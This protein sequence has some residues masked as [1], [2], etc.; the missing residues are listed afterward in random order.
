MST[1]K[2]LRF[3]VIVFIFPI[4]VYA[5]NF[6]GNPSGI[7]W[8]QINSAGARVIFPA[9]LD[10]Q[11][12]RIHGIIELLDTTT[13]HSIGGVRRKW[14]TVLLNQ[15]TFSN[16]Y[17]RLAPVLSEFYMT[18]NQN[19]FEEGGLRW[20][21]NLVIHENRHMQQLANF[22]KGITK[23]F[24]FFLGQEGQLLA[25]GITIPNYFFEGDAV[26]QETLVSNQG[27]GRMPYFYNGFKALW[28]ENKHYSWMKLRSGSY[29]DF[30]PDHYSLGYQL[31]AYGNATYGEDFWKKV[32]QDAVRF[33]GI[34]Y[35]FNRAIQRYSGKS[36]RQFRQAALYFFKAQSFSDSS[37]TVQYQYLT[38]TKRNN[39]VDY[40][41]PVYINDDS[42]LVTKQS[43]REASAFY[44]LVN[45]K[46]KKLRVKNTTL[47]AYYSYNHGKIVYAS[48]QSDP[49]RANRDYSVLQ[50]VDIKTGKQKQITRK[51]KYFSPDINKDATEIIAV[52]VNTDGTNYLHRISTNTGALLIQVPNPNNYFF[53]QTKYI[54]ANNAATIVR[55]AEGKIAMLKI[56]LTTGATDTIIDFSFTLL[57]YP[58]VKDDSIYFNAGSGYN[59]KIFAVSIISKKIISVSNNNN[60]I[61]NPV[62][63]GRGE[64]LASAFTA[65]GFR[66]V[67]IYRT[68]SS[69]RREETKHLADL[70]TPSALQGKG[71]G[72]LYKFKQNEATVTSYKK[73]FQLFN[74]H[75]RRAVISDPK[76]GYT[77]SS[78]NVLSSFSNN[79]TYTYNRNE[80]SHS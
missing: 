64:V 66:L 76:Y 18:P 19:N 38:H 61:Y 4:S 10:S 14:N 2:C 16:A 7:K 23:I 37:S 31:V 27:R 20:D 56:D 46:E 15:T 80:K 40:L 41:Y 55:N 29:R 71:A 51:S 59:D 11:A 17:V 6:G 34:F 39:V 43:Y 36:Y 24:S 5:Q 49:R 60:G 67:K 45:G 35:P 28:Q 69:G 3:I 53:T 25:N 21:D 68:N 8:R 9:G 75:S 50:V 12:K 33:K 32:T 57:G 74:F 30:T 13:I 72:V 1:V 22:N 26:W 62:V 52:Q 65:G 78:N 47:D 79:I 44:V 70:Y 42:L 48:Y 54:D 77:F 63:N 58:F 73:S